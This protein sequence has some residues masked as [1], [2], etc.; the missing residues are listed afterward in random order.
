LSGNR[1]AAWQQPPLVELLLLLLIHLHLLL[2]L[3]DLLLQLGV[4]AQ[5]NSFTFGSEE[6]VAEDIVEVQ[7]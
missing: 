7:G 4:L 6:A 1:F 5:E 2:L 3:L